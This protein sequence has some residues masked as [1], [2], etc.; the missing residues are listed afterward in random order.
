MVPLFQKSGQFLAEIVLAKT[1]LIT[2]TENTYSK[3]LSS[4]CMFK[5]NM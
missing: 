4:H 3:K 1:A 5:F 2:K